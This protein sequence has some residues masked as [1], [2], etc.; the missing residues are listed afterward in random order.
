MS[1]IEV[2]VGL[3]R[4]DMIADLEGHWGPGIGPDFYGESN[5]R[6]AAW[7]LGQCL[8]EAIS[9]SPESLDI[10]DEII[11]LRLDRDSMSLELA[12]ELRCLVLRHHDR[13]FMVSGMSLDVFSRADAYS[14]GVVHPV[15]EIV[16]T[17]APV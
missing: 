5:A 1:R 3:S 7:H 8:G 10:R 12:N 15:A 14:N 4:G 11:Y 16:A 6:I 13:P 9:F 17:F 2:H